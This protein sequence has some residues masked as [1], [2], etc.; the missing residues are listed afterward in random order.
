MPNLIYLKQCRLNKIKVKSLNV[1]R[2]NIRGG[3]AKWDLRKNR[4]KIRE[5]ELSMG[6]EI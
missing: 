5:F 2:W 1:F 4:L 3:Y 6:S